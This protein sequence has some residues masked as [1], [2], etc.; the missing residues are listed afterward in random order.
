MDFAM[1]GFSPDG[2]GDRAQR[3]RGTGEG[4]SR[5]VRF[6]PREEAFAIPDLIRTKI[7]L[8]PPE[9]RRYA[10]SRSSA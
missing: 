1:E 6:L 5:A 10:S 3:Q 8:L 7:N 2:A 4:I 9:L